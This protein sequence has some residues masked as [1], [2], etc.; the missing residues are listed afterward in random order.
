MMIG[1]VLTEQVAIPEISTAFCRPM[2]QVRHCLYILLSK[3]TF[4]HLLSSSVGR[5][6]FVMI[7]RMDVI[8]RRENMDA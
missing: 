5:V 6:L 1:E 7:W 3:N 8:G 2:L 4:L